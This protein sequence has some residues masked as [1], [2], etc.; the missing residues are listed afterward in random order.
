LAIITVEQVKQYTGIT[1]TPTDSEIQAAIYVI[2]AAVKKIT[3]NKFNNQIIGKTVI[4]S[5]LV[6]IYSLS[7]DVAKYWEKGQQKS[8]SDD[9]NE[10]IE[11]GAQ[12]NGPGIP[13]GSFVK[14]IYSNGDSVELSGNFYNIPVVELSEAATASNDN[15]ELFLNISIGYLPVIAKAVYWQTQQV[16]LKLPGAP[17]KSKTMGPLSIT[18]SDKDSAVNGK[19]GVPLWLVKSLPKYHRGF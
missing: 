9:L 19:Y 3:R 17:A 12:I 16:N 15:A 13:A 6:E 7:S 18:L 2:D 8:Y 14:Q 11:P 1:T 4:G 10:Y 5:E